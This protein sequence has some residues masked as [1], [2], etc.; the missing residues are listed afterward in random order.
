MYN[1]N[2]KSKLIGAANSVLT[3]YK[4]KIFPL[5]LSLTLINACSNMPSLGSKDDQ[6]GMA[7]LL[8]GQGKYV[9]ASEIYSNL[10][11]RSAEKN[12]R[13]HYLLLAAETLV[14][15]KLYT[16]GGQSKIEVIEE[17]LVSPDLQSRLKI[18]KSKEALITGDPQGALS[19]LPDPEQ[20]RSSAHRARIYEVRANAFAHLGIVDEELNA[21]VEL[22]E[23][24]IVGDSL[25]TN[26]DHIWTLIS[27]QTVE[28]LR[29]MTTKVHGDIYQGWLELA[30]ILRSNSLNAKYMAGQIS[31]WK[32]RFPNHPAI[33]QFVESRLILALDNLP[34]EPLVK[35][36]AILL[37]LSG[38]IAVAARTIRDGLIATYLESV[39]TVNPPLLKF[40][41]TSIRD[42]KSVYRQAVQEGANFIIGPLKKSSVKLLASEPA[43]PVPT[44]ALNYI[45]PGT[46]I[47]ADNLI[48]FGLLPED[49]AAS[50]ALKARQLNYSTALILSSDDALGTRLS[51]AFQESFE[52]AN[53][54]ILETVILP[55]DN[56]DYSA[57]LQKV[58][59]IGQSHRRHQKLQNLTGLALKFEPSIR[60]DI[61]VI[62]L[63]TDAQQAQL[64]RPQLLFF[65]ARNIPLL[66]SSRVNSDVADKQKNRDLDGIIFSDSTW[67]L[68]LA[69]PTNS[70]QNA[71]VKNW[72]DRLDQAKLFALGSDAFAVLPYLGNMRGNPDY[73]FPGGTGELSLDKENR[74]HRHLHWARFE[75]GKAVLFDTAAK[76]LILEN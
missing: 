2:L 22:D 73:R 15:N 4:L 56:Y 38:K 24:L 34:D 49:E 63:T 18:L 76:P 51:L 1:Y 55:K 6:P 33:G 10:A 65:R 11:K 53:G 42:L 25:A 59:R 54:K 3:K 29:Q 43:L 74:I 28:S 64:I 9:E 46:T 72:P 71:I 39:D 69:S 7:Q 16:Q 32:Q 52:A 62:F 57:E 45:S 61:D 23:L 17:V 75:K 44:L 58:L 48:Q 70:I 12:E 35:N 47:V 19:L 67:S 60:Q 26:H 5:I 20:I 41:D 66:A 21:R 27:G 37:P 50:A 13:Q 30:L 36:L 14:D 68:T 8:I 40:Y 31:N